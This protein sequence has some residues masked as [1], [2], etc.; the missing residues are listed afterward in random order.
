[1][2]KFLSSLLYSSLDNSNNQNIQLSNNIKELIQLKIPAR[3]FREFEYQHKLPKL[4]QSIFYWFKL[5]NTELLNFRYE[6]I[7]EGETIENYRFAPTYIK[8]YRIKGI[9]QIFRESGKLELESDINFVLRIPSIVNKYYF[10]I[11]GNKYIPSL[12]YSTRPVLYVPNKISVN[13]LGLSLILNINHVMHLFSDTYSHLTSVYIYFLLY[14]PFR[15]KESYKN[16]AK[17]LYTN[18]SH[19]NKIGN[20]TMKS[21]LYKFFKS[22]EKE[23]IRYREKLAKIFRVFIPADRLYDTEKDFAKFIDELLTN[24]FLK[25][26]FNKAL[27]AADLGI[28]YVKNLNSFSQLIRDIIDR[29]ILTFEFTEDMN[30]AY[31]SNRR[32]SIYET[33]LSILNREILKYIITTVNV[34]THKV[35]NIPKNFLERTLFSS[36]PFNLNIYDIATPYDAVLGHKFVNFDGDEDKTLLEYRIPNETYLGRICLVSTS[37]QKPGIDMHTTPET[38]FN[39]FGYITDLYR[40]RFDNN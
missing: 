9:L 12:H 35:F 24:M 19:N 25:H 33:L 10:I 5:I 1:M 4:I 20:Y 26:P 27:L 13:T 15:D 6:I 38:T 39:Y 37:S 18:L 22:I 11:K 32:V 23:F 28:D 40:P 16:F 17:F 34:T 30:Y 29:K 14:D 21:D 7:D 36:H 3:D 2:K 8:K 31:L